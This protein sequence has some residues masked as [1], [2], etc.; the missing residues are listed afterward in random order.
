MAYPSN[1][2][3]SGLIFGISE[4]DGET[5]VPITVNASGQLVTGGSTTGGSAASTSL[6]ESFYEATADA[7]DYTTGD[8]LRNREVLDASGA[9]VSSIWTNLD[10]GENID[11]PPQEDISFK[12]QNALTDDELRASNVGV[13]DQANEAKLEELR[14]ILANIFAD[15]TAIETLSES[16]ESLLQELNTY[17][18][19]VESLLNTVGGNTQN[20]ED[21]LTQLGLNTDQVEAKQDETIAAINLSNEGGYNYDTTFTTDADGNI[22][23]QTRTRPDGAGGTITESRTFGWD[24]DGNIQS[25]SAWS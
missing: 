16:Q 22:A 11:E 18:D 7:S 1:P 9:P 10:T 17:N 24:A 25:I 12:T 21:L 15:T 20:L 14:A 6:A 23:S 2:P 13:Y 4:I 19:E 8:T 5:Y 3:V